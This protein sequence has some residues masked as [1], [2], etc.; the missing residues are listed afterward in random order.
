M[1]STA[2]ASSSGDRR[3]CTSIPP[4]RTSHSIF[5]CSAAMVQMSAPPPLMVVLLDR[6][7]NSLLGLVIFTISALPPL[8]VAIKTPRTRS[9]NLWSTSSCFL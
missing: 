3:F 1:Y 4:G 7:L 8:M 6:L 9:A 5:S 2:A